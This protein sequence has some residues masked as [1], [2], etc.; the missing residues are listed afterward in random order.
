[1]MGVDE[2]RAA[3]GAPVMRFLPAEESRGPVLAWRRYQF[4]VDWA[5]QFS[6]SPGDLRLHLEVGF[7]DGRYTARRALALPEDAFVGL[8]ISSASMARALRR[9][10]REQLGNVRLLKAAAQFALRQLFAPGTLQSVTVNF[11]DPW[12]KE[13]HANNRL[14]RVPFFEL[15]ASRLV[16]GGRILLA[17]DHPD[18]L[19]FSRDQARASGLFALEDAAPPLAVF[20]TKYALK[21]K[22]QGKPLYYQAFVRRLGPA[23][24]RSILKR[25]EI[26]PHAIL[27]GRLPA[28]ASFAKQVVPYADGYVILQEAARSFGVESASGERWLVRV[29]VDEPDLRQALLVSVRRRE[30]GDLIVGLEP[31]GD[32]VVTKAVRGAVHAVIEWLLTLDADLRV[33]TRDY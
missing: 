9:M 26:M 23:P 6:R 21:W 12:P 18:Y 15:A 22:E 1:M 8:E 13:R 33:M 5:A 2:L 32:P 16:P 17:T 7:G 3:N 11:P 24:E 27:T 4:P 30:Q 20:E 19:A 29:T 25:S 14:L 31:F 10:K 28:E